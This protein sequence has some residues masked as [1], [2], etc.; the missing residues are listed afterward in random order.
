MQYSSALIFFSHFR[1][2]L[3]KGLSYIKRKQRADGSF[4]GSWGVCFT[5]G[6]WFAL[7]AFS[8]MGLT[9]QSE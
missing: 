7:E 2:V 9:Y 6:A 3:E 1:D 4:L 5:Y 8:C